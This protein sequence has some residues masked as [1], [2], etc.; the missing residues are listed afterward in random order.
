MGFS[1]SSEDGESVGLNNVERL[2]GILQ[3]KRPHQSAAEEACLDKYVRPYIELLGG[4]E[5]E[6]GII[7][8]IKQANGGQ[9]D[10]MFS[11]HTDTVHREGGEQEL[12]YDVNMGVLYKTDKEP[13]GADDGAGMWVMLAMM[14]ARKPGCYIFH[15]GEER[16]GIGSSWLAKHRPEFFKG[17]KRAVAFDRRSVD[18]VI[19]Y[20][21]GGRCCSDEFAKALADAL[22]EAN[23][24]FEY[25]PDSTG[26]FTDTANYTHIIPECTNLSV[27]YYD[28][29]TK[30]EMLD[31]G[32][33]AMLKDAALA[34]DWDLLPTHRTPVDWRDAWKGSFRGGDDLAGYYGALW[35]DT[36]GIYVAGPQR[37]GGTLSTNKP[38]RK[39]SAS[40]FAQGLPP[41]RIR[42]LTVINGGKLVSAPRGLRMHSKPEYAKTFIPLDERIAGIYD[43]AQLPY[44]DLMEAVEQDPELAADI[45]FAYFQELED[46]PVITPAPF[47]TDSVDEAVDRM[48]DAI[49]NR[50]EGPE[51]TT[52]DEVT[53]D[54]PALC[55][56]LDGGEQ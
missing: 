52:I 40:T 24:M 47:A 8:D 2:L 33:L 22:N 41:K 7:F 50:T 34:I 38:R 45:L 6:G 21:R 19:T 35:D 15:R 55:R 3:I 11:C 28:E 39:K 36:E 14:D 12:V 25:K 37:T 54:I 10:T 56:P 43:W 17:F 51:P 16:G 46:K 27:G 42:H 29:H 53:P 20:Q 18:S 49:D 23:V 32:H 9:S 44:W 13:L 1:E 5:T 26:L 48:L 30:D 4:E 31:V